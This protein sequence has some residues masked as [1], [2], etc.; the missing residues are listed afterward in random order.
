M[1]AEPSTY[2]GRVPQDAEDPWVDVGT[3]SDYGVSIRCILTEPASLAGR[4]L[5]VVVPAHLV[6]PLLQEVRRAAIELR[7]KPMEPGPGNVSEDVFQQTLEELSLQI[8]GRVRTYQV[9]S[10]KDDQ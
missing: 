5:V 7:S 10:Q 1:K 8:K 4:R 6:V 2:W 3:T 9:R